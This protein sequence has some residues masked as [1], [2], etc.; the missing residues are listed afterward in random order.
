MVNGWL[1]ATWQTFCASTDSENRS[2]GISS[3]SGWGPSASD[4]GGEDSS[5]SEIIENTLVST[6]PCRQWEFF[7]AKPP[8]NQL[9]NADQGPWNHTADVDRPR[10]TKRPAK[11]A[12]WGEEIW[13][14]YQAQRAKLEARRK[15]RDQ[16]PRP[17]LHNSKLRP[18]ARKGLL[19]EFQ[20]LASS[21]LEVVTVEVERNSVSVSGHTGIGNGYSLSVQTLDYLHPERVS[22]S[23]NFLE[24][25]LASLNVIGRVC[26]MSLATKEG[27]PPDVPLCNGLGADRSDTGSSGFELVVQI[28]DNLLESYSKPCSATGGANENWRKNLCLIYKLLAGEHLPEVAKLVGYELSRDRDS[29]YLDQIRTDKEEIW[30]SKIVDYD[31]LKDFS[32]SLV[33]L[34]KD[35]HMVLWMCDSSNLSVAAREELGILR[36]LTERRLAELD[37]LYAEDVTEEQGSIFASSQDDFMPDKRCNA[38]VRTVC[39]CDFKKTRREIARGAPHLQNLVDAKTGQVESVEAASYLGMRILT[40]LYKHF[41]RAVRGFLNVTSGSEEI[42]SDIHYKARYLR[43]ERAFVPPDIKR[44]LNLTIRYRQAATLACD[45]PSGYDYRDGHRHYTGQLRDARKEINGIDK[46]NA[47]FGLLNCQLRYPLDRPFNHGREPKHDKEYGRSFGPA[48]SVVIASRQERFQTMMH[49]LDRDSTHL[50]YC[51][52]LKA[53]HDWLSVTKEIPES[54]H[55]LVD[56]YLVPLANFLPHGILLGALDNTINGK[57]RLGY[58]SRSMCCCRPPSPEPHCSGS[59]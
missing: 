50:H 12:E 15:A 56:K 38:L 47:K 17:W 20:A 42:W 46:D 35:A 19:E 52:P 30:V 22:E 58:V 1:Q 13:E 51:P 49:S 34:L 59:W 21:A 3:R 24:E 6:N 4:A 8:S 28:G 37:M 27:Y 26:R 14:E 44:A 54:V 25:V 48:I 11:A 16:R 18:P 5:E 33:Q 41:E 57:A 9:Q 36:E 7:Q 43:R 53:L 40:R 29:Q 39:R 23:L 45:E 2:S 55:N 31:F 10:T 32:W